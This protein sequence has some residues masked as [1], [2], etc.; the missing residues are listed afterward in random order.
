MFVHQSGKKD[1]KKPELLQAYEEASG[2]DQRCHK[3]N[4]Q[5]VVQ[6]FPIFVTSHQ[7][8]LQENWK[9]RGA[10]YSINPSLRFL[11]N[12][13][14]RHHLQQDVNEEDTHEWNWATC[15]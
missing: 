11:G 7:E 1:L 3:E 12:R 5:S 2:Q 14:C 4:L 13:T 10:A 6:D 9:C 8:Q 15:Y